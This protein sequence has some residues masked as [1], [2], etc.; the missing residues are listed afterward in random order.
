MPIVS[1]GYG[2]T[3]RL[4]TPEP[5]D[6]PRWGDTQTTTQP[7]ALPTVDTTY[8]PTP[9]EQPSIS[10]DF[11]TQ[12]PA[13]TLPDIGSIADSLV[14]G[15]QQDNANASLA[16]KVTSLG[17][18]ASAG[19]SYSGARS[20]GFG[21]SAYGF[22]GTTGQASQRGSAPYGL[23]PAM[24]SALGKANAAMKAAGLGTFG[25]TD[26][27]RS[28]ALQVT[29]KQ[30]KGALAATPGRSVHGLGLAADLRL[31]AKQ[32]AWLKKNGGRFGLINLPSEAWHWQLDPRLA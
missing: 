14:A 29:T 4:S 1:D 32:T 10:Q 3:P 21:P 11:A 5:T 9:V 26:G 31:T 28:Y 22:K 24:W 8:T 23:Q 16:S 30:K 17:V 6:V 15:R 12:M 20:S 19:G 2:F 27:F 13:L 25:I 7:S 18:E